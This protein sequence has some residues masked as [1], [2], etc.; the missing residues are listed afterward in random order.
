ML[1]FR[2]TA[3]VT[4]GDSAEH[5]VHEGGAR[6]GLLQYVGHARPE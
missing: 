5:A 2:F 1:V 6:F 3:A 4:M